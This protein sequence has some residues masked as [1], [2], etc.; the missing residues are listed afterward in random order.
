LGF[1]GR[2]TA[3]GAFPGRPTDAARANA[4]DDD[5][6]EGAGGGCARSTLT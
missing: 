1:G 5:E 6:D 3:A 4:D 2:F